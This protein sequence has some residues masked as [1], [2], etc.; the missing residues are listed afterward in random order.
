MKEQT[1]FLQK[2][3]AQGKKSN[4]WKKLKGFVFFLYQLNHLVTICYIIKKKVVFLT[5]LQLQHVTALFPTTKWQLMELFQMVVIPYHTKWPRNIFNSKILTHTK[6]Q[7]AAK[8]TCAKRSAGVTCLLNYWPPDLPV[9]SDMLS[10]FFS[11]PHPILRAPLGDPVSVIQSFSLFLVLFFF[12]E[13]SSTDSWVLLSK[14]KRYVNCF[15]KKNSAECD[16]LQPIT[17]Y[18]L[19]VRL[20]QILARFS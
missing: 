7:E 4:L 9:L 16:Y 3:T 14:G 15:R 20:T 19:H 5:S 8:H 11:C 1:F 10:T 6:K 18:Y 2:S 12:K 17:Q 13:N